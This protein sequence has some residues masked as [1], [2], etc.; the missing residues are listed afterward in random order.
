MRLIQYATGLNIRQERQGRGVLAANLY[1][2][3][4]FRHTFVSFCADAGVPEAVVASIV[5]HDTIAMTRHYTHISAGAKQR[6]IDMLTGAN[7]GNGR[8]AR[9][10]LIEA[11]DGASE[12]RI[13]AALEVLRGKDN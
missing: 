4:S 3:H 11:L 6:A 13:L 1:S 5:G 10:R 12:E 9:E 7:E 8:S 2:L